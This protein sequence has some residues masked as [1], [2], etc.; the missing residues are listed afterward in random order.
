MV[1]AVMAPMQ[2]RAAVQVM[3]VTGATVVM[4]TMARTVAPLPVAMATRD[5]QPDW[6]RMAP[7]ALAAPREVMV[8]R[9]RRGD[10]EH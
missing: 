5:H 3:E 10:Q 8:L 6:Q 9:V 7:V 2:A 1:T 4:A